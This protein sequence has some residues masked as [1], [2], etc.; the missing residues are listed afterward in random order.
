MASVNW[1][2]IRQANVKAAQSPTFDPGPVDT[3]PGGDD[4]FNNDGLRGTGPTSSAG[5]FAS[6]PMPSPMGGNPRDLWNSWYG[7][8]S[9]K[10]RQSQNTSLQPFVDYLTSQGITGARV[11]VDPHGF[12]KGID[13]NGQFIKLLDGYD[14]PIWEDFAGGGGG[15]STDPHADLYFNELMARMEQLR[16]PVNDPLA[17]L[18]QLMALERVK[19]LQGDPFTGG[20]DA[21]LTARYMNPLTQAR[22]ASLQRNREAIGA[23][24][25]LPSSGLLQELNQDTERGYEQNVAAGSN[26]LA[27]RAVNER[28]ARQQ[29]QLQVLSQLLGFGR[30]QRTEQD[31]RANELIKLAAE[32]PGFDERRLG[33]LMDAGNDNSSAQGANAVLNQ[34]SIQ[35]RQQIENART[36]AERDKAW[37]DFFGSLIDNWDSI[38]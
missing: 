31:Q 32:F 7:S 13:L 22:D 12:G 3:A 14:N 18:Y 5:P 29:E 38:F 17:P 1:D 33:M 25:M 24:G 30:T 15:G 34:Q 36:Q 27:V 6:A 26:D 35:L 19:K 37:G 16:K 2:A 8:A 4:F 20:E 9:S 23:R 11:N 28:Q 10:P 21:A